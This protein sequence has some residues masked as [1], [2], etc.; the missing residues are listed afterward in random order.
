MASVPC[1]VWAL[2]ARGDSEVSPCQGAGLLFWKDKHRRYLLLRFFTP[3][4]IPWPTH[5]RA[6]L[7]T[8]RPRESGK[9]RKRKRLKPT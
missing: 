4:A 7:L 1:C 6:L 5:R 9:K 3:T 8:G 2:G